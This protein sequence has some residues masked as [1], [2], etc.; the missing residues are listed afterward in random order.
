MQK[1]EACII[2][3]KVL[4]LT[5]SI[6]SHSSETTNS[7][8]PSLSK[9]CEEINRKRQESFIEINQLFDDCQNGLR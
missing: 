4:N 1:Q 9:V 8:L 3:F 5:N 7:L 2:I 6:R